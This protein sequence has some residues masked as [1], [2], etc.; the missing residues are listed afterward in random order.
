M[1]GL[2]ALYAVMSALAF[3]LYAADKRRAERGAWRISEATLH[4]VEMLGGW[5]GALLAQRIIR[6]KRRK[7]AYMLVFWAIVIV[8]V[9][10]WAWLAGAFRR[11]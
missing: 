9:A 7:P 10:A 3:A 6:H 8:H 5:P 1:I 11:A 4:A 2:L